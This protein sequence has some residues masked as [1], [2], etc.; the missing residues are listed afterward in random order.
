MALNSRTTL[1]PIST[2]FT[3]DTIASIPDDIFTQKQTFLLFAIGMRFLSPLGCKFYKKKNYNCCL[4]L[5]NQ[6]FYSNRPLIPSCLLLKPLH[7]KTFHLLLQFPTLLRDIRVL[8]TGAQY[9]WSRDSTT[10]FLSSFLWHI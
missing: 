9:I 10:G 8:L 5:A 6:Y 7:E 2:S 1:I 4:D 3:I